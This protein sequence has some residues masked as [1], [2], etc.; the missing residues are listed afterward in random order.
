MDD[1]KHKTVRGGALKGLAQVSNFA[2]R[3]GSMAALAR[4][5]EPRDFG[6]V[7]MVT[8][9]T[10][11]LALFKDAGLSLPTVRNTTITQEQVS[12]L[13]WL[14]VLVGAVL[15]AACAAAAPALAEFYRDERLVR[16]TLWTA[17]GFLL[18]A[19]GVQHNALLERQMRFSVLSLIDVT[20]VLLSTLTAVAMA[21][22]GCGYWSL[23][24]M[25]LVQPGVTTLGAWL[26]SRWIPG[27]PRRAAEIG[28][29][30]RLGGALT[31]NGIIIYFA[32][33]TD[34]IL[35][36][37]FWGA[38]T[39]GNYGRA[40]QLVNIPTDNLNGAIGSVALAAIS[41]LREQPERLRAYFLKGYSLVVALTVPCTVACA[42]FAPEIVAIVLG[43]KWSEAAAIARLLAP[44]ILV[45]GLINP[46]FW[47][48]F[49]AGLM[50]RSLWMAVVIAVLV[51]SAYAIG[52]PYGPKG[53][54]AAYS[55]AM[56]LWLVPHLVWCLHGTVIR[57]VD[58]ARAAGRPLAA[59]L[60]A[61][62]VCVGL[63]LSM[64][65]SLS[66][67]PRLTVGLTV[68]GITYAGILLIVFRQL[69]FYQDLL[70]TLSVRPASPAPS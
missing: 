14:N 55:T 1:L 68:L 47:L 29:M 59:G 54:A 10:G 27:R 30:L 3:I 64:G 25:T 35:L 51:I 37:R 70:K 50:G 11:V 60:A 40:Y 63:Q 49:S 17:P 28:S 41:R 46:A 32:Y 52:L 15:T 53:V 31:L 43:P 57:P 24:G 2:L 69:A 61:A 12:T 21:W 18:N 20:S 26:A 45:F 65:D 16:V 22:L 67:V 42:V 4:L 38:A 66:V 56:T 39:L 9:V 34:K 36:G 48:I 5:L 19:L 62:L 33:N 23:V 44:T 7:A 13:F 6:L 58:L 8:A